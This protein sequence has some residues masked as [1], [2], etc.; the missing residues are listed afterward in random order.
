MQP[1]T[2]RPKYSVT[3]PSEGLPYL[4]ALPGG[5]VSV[6]PIR[7]K[8]EKILAGLQDNRWQEGLHLL[9]KSC[10]A[11]DFDPNELTL[12]DRLFLLFQ[13]RTLSYG[14]MYDFEITCPKDG[15]QFTHSCDLTKL[16]VKH[17]PADF[18]EPFEILLPSSN[19]VV[20]LRLLRPKDEV[21]L[22]KFTDAQRVR[23]SKTINEDSY[24]YRLSLHITSVE[25]VALE[26][27]ERMEWV[28]N[29][30]GMDSQAIQE[31]VEET[32]SGLDGTVSVTCPTCSHQINQS[33]PWTSTFF[34]PRKRV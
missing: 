30:I 25:G 19:Q 18:K 12:S 3:L 34:R 1:V 17:L 23:K 20:G 6:H 16:A 27:G 13:L 29:L 33:I 9:L 2:E 21:D 24:S 22:R 5:V 28:E 10:L 11:T 7:V 14:P 8:E 26:P 32:D 15:V 4:G 31:A